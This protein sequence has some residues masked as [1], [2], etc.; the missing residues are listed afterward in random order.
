[1]GVELTQW[2]LVK[3]GR[4]G[5]SSRAADD[6]IWLK[7]PS[8]EME[9]LPLANLSPEVRGLIAELASGSKVPKEN[10]GDILAARGKAGTA[11][12]RLAPRPWTFH[13]LDDAAGLYVFL[14]PPPER[15]ARPVA[16]SLAGLQPPMRLQLELAS[17]GDAVAEDVIAALHGDA[18]AGSSD[19]GGGPVA[20]QAPRRQ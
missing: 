19:R 4:L 10:L 18:G 14:S 5:A 2:T 9:L 3:P 20:G 15:G 6:S 13:H 12:E 8:G 7:A 11:G 17:P 16:F 1:M